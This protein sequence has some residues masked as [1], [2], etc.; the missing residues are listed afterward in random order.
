MLCSAIKANLK[1]SKDSSVFVAV[2]LRDDLT[3]TLRIE[4]EFLMMETGLIAVE[5][6][7]D[8][9]FY[10][11]WAL[12]NDDDDDDGGVKCWWGVFKHDMGD[13]VIE[14]CKMAARGGMSYIR[15]LAG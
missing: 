3:K 5:Q 13:T 11:E 9:Y 15:D 14:K 6:S 12:A 2:P 10:D 7:Y 4:F 1:K 8:N